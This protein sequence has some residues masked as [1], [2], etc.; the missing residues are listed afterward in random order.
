MLAQQSDQAQLSGWSVML[1]RWISMLIVLAVPH[2]VSAHEFGAK[3]ITVAHPWARATLPDSSA[4]SA[5]LEIKAAK[6]VSDKLIAAKTQA[7]GT[8]ELQNHVMDGKEAKMRRVDSITV[9]A[10]KSVVLGPTGYHVMLMDVKGKLAEG[11]V[12]K[13]TLV[14]EKAGEIEVD[15]S[16]EPANAT[17]PHGF[18][19]QP[20]HEPAKTGKKGSHAH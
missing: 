18:T 11:D 20:G 8:V 4:T 13:L 15:A 1:S 2:V 16:V 9:P 6:G 10:G 3:G 14:F 5:Y 17:G 19:Y 7:A 12:L